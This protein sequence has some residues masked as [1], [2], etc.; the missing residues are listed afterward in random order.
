MQE[1]SDLM[2]TLV[3]SYYV[4]RSR[5]SKGQGYLSHQ[6][7]LIHRMKPAPRSSFMSGYL[8]FCLHGQVA[9]GKVAAALATS[10]KWGVKSWP[11]PQ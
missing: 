4:E 6:M 11:G 3:I 1:P 5:V 10:V 8:K 9:G 2:Q 7:L